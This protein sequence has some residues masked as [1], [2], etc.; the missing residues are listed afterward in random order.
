MKKYLS[1]LLILVSV[2]AHAA[3]ENPFKISPE[4]DKTIKAGLHELYNFDF[5][6]SLKIFASVK[7]QEEEHPMIAFGAASAN[8]W[9]VTTSVL[10][11]DKEASK[12]FL[13]SI[14]HCIDVSQ[15]KIKKGD[16]TGEGYLTL[17][18]ALGL[19]GR[20]Q[21]TNQEWTG[22][23]FKGKKA[24]KNLVKALEVNPQM[25]DA[26]MGK[27][28]FDYYVAT[29]PSVVRVLAF[30]GMGGDK[31]IGLQELTV[32]ATQ[33]TYS[34]TASTLFLV[35]IYSNAEGTPEKGLPLLEDLR[36]DYPKSFF[37]HMVEMIA[38]YNAGR[39]DDLRTQALAY[40][41]KVKDGTY[42]FQAVAPGFFALGISHLK[43]KEWNEA[44]NYFKQSFEVND[45]SNPW[46][47]WS[48]LYY[49]YCLDAQ[50]RRDEAL[51]A[52]KEV[53]AQTRRWGSHDNAKARLKKPF[54]GSDEDL[55]KLV[56]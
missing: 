25:L 40:Q 17:G 48:R 10:E 28:I 53:L 9:R 2:T 32:A 18:G 20:W 15:R 36:K 27:G 1:A 38:L 54:S 56:L 51:K 7:D 52:Y 11:T 41:E 37:I 39:L 13:E 47:T 34:R 49:G 24:Y 4:L 43:K 5:D 35:D 29:L 14:N 21:A 30:I 46:R 12:E 19:L 42:G 45:P 26:N 55:K 3:D 31:N 33:G 16:A 44:E 8:W 22:A 23:Y 50:G 6:K